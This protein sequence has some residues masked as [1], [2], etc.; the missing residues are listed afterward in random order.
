MRLILTDGEGHV[1]RTRPF[2]RSL[3]E[4]ALAYAADGRPTTVTMVTSQP[5]ADW[6]ILLHPALVDTPLGYRVIELDRFVD[7]FTSRASWRA[8]LEAA[9][10]G[11]RELYRLAWARRVLTLQAQGLPFRDEWK[12]FAEAQLQRARRGNLAGVLKDPSALKDPAR[13]PLTAKPEFFD[14]ELVDWIIAAAGGVTLEGFEQ[15]ITRQ[16]ESKLASPQA[17]WFKRHPDWVRE[18][19][20]KVAEYN[21]SVDAYSEAARR[22]AAGVLKDELD[23]LKKAGESNDAWYDRLLAQWLTAEVPEFEVWSGVREKPFAVEAADVVVVNGSAVPMPF[24]FML[25]IAFTTPAWFASGKVP[26]DEKGRE[27]ARAYSDTHPWEFPAIAPQ[28]QRAVLTGVATAGIADKEI[29][30]DA[31]EFTLLQRLFRLGFEKR[32]GEDFPVEEL[33]R[34]QRAVAQGTAQVTYRTLRWHSRRGGLEQQLGGVFETLDQELKD[35]AAESKG[36][37]SGDLASSVAECETLVEEHIRAHFSEEMKLREI[38]NG[39]QTGD[40]R[41]LW[42]AA[43]REREANQQAWEGRWEKAFGLFLKWL[44]PA[45]AAVIRDKVALRCAIRLFLR[46]RSPIGSPRP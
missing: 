41:A 44:E 3:V 5:L 31:S 43:W 28:I 38:T 40:R 20:D 30:T 27:R 17:L 2:R 46:P 34:L 1:L 7:R 18:Y 29:L 25:Q 21:S 42:D 16:A 36:L 19:N 15:A 23:Q 4:H 6:R 9:V 35:A 39:K 24:D 13:S 10:Q 37:W 26:M 32:L 33:A 22:G 8:D 14:R 11:Q 45:K 12:E